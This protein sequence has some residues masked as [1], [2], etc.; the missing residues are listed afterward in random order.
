MPYAEYFR[1]ATE[2]L[3]IVDRSGRIV[4][5][6]SEAERLFGYSEAEL[7]GRPVELLVPEHLRQSHAG[8]VQ[9]YFAAPRTRAMG[10][11]LSLAGRRKDGSEFPLEISLTY[12]ADTNRGELVVAAVVDITA[13]LA[14]EQEV[15]KAETLTSLGILVAG[16]AHDLNNPL[17]VIRSRA[18]LLLDSPEPPPAEILADVGTIHRQAQRASAIVEQ[19]LELSRNRER[20]LAPV[21]VNALIDRT[22]LLIGDELRKSGISLET[23]LAADLPKVNGDAIA[24]ERVLINLL[25]NAREAM[26]QGGAITI[27]S[28]LLQVDEQASLHITVTDNGPGIPADV[29][30]KIFDLLYTTKSDGS[31]LGLWLSRRI[32]QEHHGRMDV[33]SRPGEGT[34][35]NIRLPAFA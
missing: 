6:N 11:G 17:Q 23:H 32:V 29:L 31:G 8:Y 20:V 22:L 26:P 35:F 5:A 3:I 33:T 10:R 15:R 1:S 28:R 21:D 16:I 9:S 19:F 4:E 25:T 13:R 27:A 24:L 2:G 18:E 34:T 7:Q 30:G 14:L 12:A